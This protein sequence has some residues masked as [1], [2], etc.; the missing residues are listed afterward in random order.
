MSEHGE[1]VF[2]PIGFI[3]AIVA[4]PVI[5]PAIATIAATAVGVAAVGTAGY[6][7]IK[8]GSAIAEAN[9]NSKRNQSYTGVNNMSSYEESRWEKRQREREQR[10]FE[11]EERQRQWE[12]R[13]SE[14]QRVWEEQ[15][16]I[17][18]EAHLNRVREITLRFANQHKNKFADLERQSLTQ[19]M[20]NEFANIHSQL[21][22]LD[23]LLRDDPEAAMELSKQIGGELSSLPLLA[24]DAKREFEI[25]EK[26]RQQELSEMRRQATTELEQLLESLLADIKDPIEADYAFD[27]LKTMQK[28][29]AGYSVDPQQ[30]AQLKGEI[31][32]KV[33]A[34]RSEAAKKAS[35]WKERKT[36]ANV[37]E[38]QQAAIEMLEENVKQEQFV[39]P[40]LVQDV[41]ANLA[42]LKK[43]V[44][45]SNLTN[46]EVL[47]QA[48]TATQKV[49]EVV[50]DETARKIVV[51]SIMESLQKTGFVV[52]NPKR[53][54][55]E[56]DEVVIL[57]RKPAGAEA[58]FRI[59]A[60][61]GLTYKFDHY[62]G[63]K[64]KTDIKEVEEL[65]DDVYG[66]E[67]SDKRILWENPDRIKMGM[68]DNPNSINQTRFQNG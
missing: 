29:Y 67:L 18:Q 55:G 53:E 64:C 42:A 13:Q 46:E 50:A 39:N 66:I 16:R 59:T 47:Q 35:E 23:F 17:A 57:A 4:A 40:Q 56:K 28:K 58:S 45:T 24:R 31:T 62:E 36:K 25:R 32:Q 68:L 30:F 20:P 41:L 61:G 38:T 65:L 34:I 51:R 63:S 15:Q 10:R 54:K 5:L 48:A 14:R 19:Y 43:Q 7:A 1:G 21:Q 8:V 33:Q 37:K 3:G 6:G 26:Q 44:A 12:S 11:H 27:Q 60:D 9:R 2:A 22:Q 49:E 52:S